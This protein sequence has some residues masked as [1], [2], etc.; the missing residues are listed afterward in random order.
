M[1]ATILMFTLWLAKTRSDCPLPCNCSSI[2][3]TCVNQ[4]LEIVPNFKWIESSPLI[5]DL[6]GNRLLFIDEEDFNFD[7]I[8]EVKE[9]YLNNSG[10]ADIGDGTFDNVENLQELYLGQNFLTQDSVPENLIEELDNMILLELSYNYFNGNMPVIRS[11]SLEVLALANSKIT[12]LN[13]NSL[14]FLPNLKMLLLQQNNIKSI[15]F[16]TFKH[17]NQNSFFVKLSHNSWSCSC[18]NFETFTLLADKKFIDI[19]EPYQ[20]IGDDSNTIGILQIDFCK[21]QEVNLKSLQVLNHLEE[22]SD[23]DDLLEN[24]E[25]DIKD[26]NDEDLGNILPPGEISHNNTFSIESNNLFLL[27]VICTSITFAIGFICGLVFCHILYLFRYK[28]LEQS[29]DSR[30]QLL[31]A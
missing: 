9:I 20:C 1:K 28:K 15:T 27:I 24:T 30:V 5:I 23:N 19:S 7:Q 4:S 17:Y 10:I 2:A 8:D 29:S 26:L 12:N 13:E 25:I 11:D 6:S 3:I 31:N 14:K 18:A 16:D 21:H 22:Y